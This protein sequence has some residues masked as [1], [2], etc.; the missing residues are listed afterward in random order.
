MNRSKRT[1][2]R[3]QQSKQTNSAKTVGGKNESSIQE[4]INETLRRKI[5]IEAFI[6]EYLSA[7]NVKNTIDIYCPICGSDDVNVSTKQTRSI[8]EAATNFYKCLRCG[9]IS[10]KFLKD[11]GSPDF[12][13][14]IKELNENYKKSKK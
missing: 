12:K 8:D 4:I 7:D 14:Q 10:K 3:P 2:S 13:K 5:P 11:N 1:A 6:K 9:F